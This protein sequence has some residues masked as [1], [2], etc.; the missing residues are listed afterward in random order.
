MCICVCNARPHCSSAH[1]G[2][3]GTFHRSMSFVHVDVRLLPSL[4]GSKFFC[5]LSLQGNAGAWASFM[6]ADRASWECQLEQ[7]FVVSAIE[8]LADENFQDELFKRGISDLQVYGLHRAE[9]ALFFKV[10]SI[11]VS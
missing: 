7:D 6:S 4:I 9:H 2:L 5:S 8:T 3:S 1:T 11:V 10:F